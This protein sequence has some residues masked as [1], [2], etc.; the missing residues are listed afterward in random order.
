MRVDIGGVIA[1]ADSAMAMTKKAGSNPAIR[2][3]AARRR[4]LGLDVNGMARNGPFSGVARS[5]CGSASAVA[6][7]KSSHGTRSTSTGPSGVAASRWLASLSVAARRRKAADRRAGLGIE[8][9]QPHRV[10]GL[11]REQRQP[12]ADRDRPAAAQRIDRPGGGAAPIAQKSN[13]VTIG[14]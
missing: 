3:S 12:F 6:V 9:G 7:S 13:S 11:D 14:T 5:N 8:R 10:G 1:L 4:P 2:A